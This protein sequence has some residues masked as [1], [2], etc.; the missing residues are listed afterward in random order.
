MKSNRTIFLLL[1]S[2]LVVSASGQ[3][4]MDKIVEETHNLETEIKDLKSSIDGRLKELVKLNGNIKN[5]STQ[6]EKLTSQIKTLEYK[7]SK[8]VLDSLSYEIDSLN[9]LNNSLVDSMRVLDARISEE[10]RI[11]A[12]N[13]SEIAG[14]DAFSAVQKRAKMEAGLKYISK[15]YSDISNDSLRNLI[16]EAENLSSDEE[17]FAEYKKRLDYAFVNKKIFDEAYKAIDI[18][19][20]A[21]LIDSLRDCLYP[22]IVVEEDSSAAKNY[23]LSDEQFA[24]MDSCL[25]T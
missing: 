9:V 10:K 15:K 5:D 21:Q 20:N 19:Y 13:K 22:L 4:N 17:S 18:D 8:A 23:Q 16:I 24:E 14:M 3:S 25:K 1:F 2:L 6:I 11:L 7:K 12:K